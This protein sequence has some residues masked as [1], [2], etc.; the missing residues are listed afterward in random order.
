MNAQTERL[1]TLGFDTKLGITLAGWES[2]I[3]AV[4]NFNPPLYSAWWL[5]S[6]GLIGKDD[7]DEAIKAEGSAALANLCKFSTDWFAIQVIQ[8]QFSI[9]SRGPVTHALLDLVSGIFEIIRHAPVSSIGINFQAHLKFQDI[10]MY[11]AFGDALAPKDIWS[12]VKYGVGASYGLENITVC[13]QP[14]DRK[15]EAESGSKVRITVQPSRKVKAGLHLT[16][17]DHHDIEQDFKARVDTAAIAAGLIK[18]NWESDSNE[19]VRAFHDLITI[20]LADYHR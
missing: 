10:K 5:E 13:S 2:S 3:I 4:G 20:A 8:N 17:N 7:R 14:Y 19:A 1:Q 11:H 12:R 15:E 18:K 6:V 16:F 9:E